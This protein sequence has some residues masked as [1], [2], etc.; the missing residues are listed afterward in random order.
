M[1]IWLASYPKSGN[2][3]L[4]A[5]L[6]AY[7]FSQDGIFNFQ[8]LNNIKQ[9]PAKHFFEDVGIDTTDRNE[10]VKNSL[11]AQEHMSNPQTV[12]FLKTHNMLYNFNKKYP[13]TNLDNSLGVIYIVRDPRN[14]VLSYARHLCVS[15][16][17]TMKLMTIGNGIDEDIMGNWSENYK[18]WK[19]FN[20][21][22]K[23][24]LIKYEDLVLDR[25][26]TFLK[27]LKFIFNLR[28]IN[29]SIDNDKFKKT[30]DSTTFESLKNLEI[31]EGFKESIT[32]KKTGKNIKFFDKGSE[33]NW[34]T[35]LEPTIS[36]N[37]EKVFREEMMEL[38]YL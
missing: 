32:N 30:I 12:G 7:L 20:K 33:R 29:H 6:S 5:M 28:N 13:F 35:S 19:N 21:Y 18:S 24:L 22:K 31:K 26:E 14:V 3:L 11:R 16:E 37:L 2:T 8:L 17:E 27:I 25:D 10:L 15:I 1:I 36:I 9:F 23:Y 34:S 4:R 38:G